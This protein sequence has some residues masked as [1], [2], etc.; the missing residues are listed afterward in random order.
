MS[1]RTRRRSLIASVLADGTVASQEKLA[2]LLADRGVR[3]TQ[4]TLSRDLREMGV[5]K[6]PEGYVLPP[7]KTTP[8]TREMGRTLRA[9]VT[10]IRVGGTLVVLTTGPGHAQIVALEIDRASLEGAL[11][12]VAGDDTIFVAAKN[13]RAA[14]KLAAKLKEEAEL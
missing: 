4:T 5:V 2:G 12:T 7:S 11:G 3:T 13:E 14:K 8:E 10:G 9:Y 6:G 1:D